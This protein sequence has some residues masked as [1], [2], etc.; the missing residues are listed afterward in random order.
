MRQF[1]TQTEAVKFGIQLS[2]TAIGKKA[3]GHACLLDMA[4]LVMFMKSVGK[5]TMWMSSV[6]PVEDLYKTFYKTFSLSQRLDHPLFQRSQ[7]NP[8]DLGPPLQRVL[9][10]HYAHLMALAKLSL[11]L[12]TMATSCGAMVCASQRTLGENAREFMSIAG[13]GTM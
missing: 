8:I 7:P 4:E 13:E 1:V 2:R 10:K 3:L 6:E 5:A 12:M 11:L 9:V